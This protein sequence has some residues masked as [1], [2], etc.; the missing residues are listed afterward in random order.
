MGV[1][2]RTPGGGDSLPGFLGNQISLVEKC[3]KD[4]FFPEKA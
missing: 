1:S 4:F 3:I 2:G